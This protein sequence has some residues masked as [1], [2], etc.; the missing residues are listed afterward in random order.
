MAIISS[1]LLFDSINQY[2]L[3]LDLDSLHFEGYD[4]SKT[5]HYAIHVDSTFTEPRLPGSICADIYIQPYFAFKIS[6]NWGWGV[7]FILANPIEKI[8][9]KYHYGMAMNQIEINDNNTG[10]KSNNKKIND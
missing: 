8:Y 4:N 10:I 3:M 2:V 5:Y 1:I 6:K 9:T 7:D